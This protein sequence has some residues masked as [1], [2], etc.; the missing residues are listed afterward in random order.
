MF[1]ISQKC[2]HTEMSKMICARNEIHIWWY[3]QW[4]DDWMRLASLLY[5]AMY[6]RTEVLIFWDIWI[7]R[8]SHFTVFSFECQGLLF[9]PAKHSWNLGDSRENLFE[10]H[11]DFPENLFEIFAVVIISCRISSVHGL[12]I[13]QWADSYLQSIFFVY[14]N[15]F[16]SPFPQRRDSKRWSEWKSDSKHIATRCNTPHY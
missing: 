1:K 9:N 15:I 16:Y 8:L 5:I 14:C 2:Y 6:P 3:S 13:S 4:V 10:S 11:G 7:S 12:T